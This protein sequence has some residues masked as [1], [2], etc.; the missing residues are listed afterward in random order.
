MARDH[1]VRIKS[2]EYIAGI[3]MSWWSL[4]NRQ[5]QHFNICDFVLGPLTH[6]YSSKGRLVVEFYDACVGD[7]PA[8]VTFKPLT[9]HVDRHTWNLAN[10]G[11]SYARY[12]IAH[13]VGHIVLHDE[14]A[15]AFSD[16][17][18]A[19]LKYLQDEESG[20]WQA[21]TFAGFFLV[22]DYVALKLADADIIAG[23]CVV[24]NELAQKRLVDARNAKT[25]VVPSY[26]GA[27]CSECGNF[28]LVRNG[29][30]MKCERM[31]TLFAI[32]G[33]A[34]NFAACL[35]YVRAILKGEATPNRVTSPQLPSTFALT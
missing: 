32:A 11:V 9:L 30:C 2:R 17:E 29:A 18:A 27:I 20:E 26:E 16:E 34:V 24:T 4:A 33:A 5:G 1:R 6:R 13:E 14:F 12:I 7:D 8:Y 22:P 3:A 19:Q 23:L 35:S 15:V 31:Y 10:N 21:N 28:T 25:V